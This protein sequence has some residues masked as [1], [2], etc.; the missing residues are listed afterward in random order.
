MRIKWTAAMI[1]APL[2]LGQGVALAQTPPAISPGLDRQVPS[3]VPV[4][5]IENSDRIHLDLVNCSGW[6]D[7]LLSRMVLPNSMQV[8][9]YQLWFENGSATPIGVAQTATIARGQLTGYQLTENNLGLKE[10]NQTLLGNQITR[11]NL[12]VN[13][14]QIPPDHYDGKVFFML[15]DGN[16]RLTLP[17]TLNV[18]SGPLLPVFALFLGVVLGRL[19]KYMQ[20]RGGPQADKLKL[21]NRLEADLNALHPEDQKLL[22]S[23]LLSVRQLVFREEL[24]QAD[25]QISLMRARLE[26]LQKLRRIQERLEADATGNLQQ[27]L[28][29]IE[30]ARLFLSAA[31]DAAAQRELATLQD[32]LSGVRGD[33]TAADLETAVSHVAQRL[34]AK[35]AIAPIS[36]KGWRRFH[37]RKSLIGLAGV[38]DELRAEA[39]LWVVRPLLSIGLLVGLA[40]IGLNELYIEKG[41][42]L[43]AKPF[44]DYWG[45]ILW[46]L[47]ADVASRSLTSLNEKQGT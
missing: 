31:E 40:L 13:R 36:A 30:Q 47:S 34:D 15:K 20:A 19:L 46:G 18:R 26:V 10:S 6:A 2:M 25:A 29:Q 22:A 3:S 21:I 32:E 4:S 16:T 38:S 27:F 12:Q 23:M 8:D 9:T 42:T 43:G 37:L 35:A 45:L 1:V 24:T 7:C 44:S 11:L 41:T 5:P 33:A 17:V 39:T 28:P 14:L